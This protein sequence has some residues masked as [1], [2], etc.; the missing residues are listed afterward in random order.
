V[1][2]SGTASNVLRRIIWICLVFP[3]GVLLVALAV[4]NRHTVRLI[5]DPFAPDNPVLAVEAPLFL[6]LLGAVI[7]GLVLGGTVTWFGQG[8][9]RRTARRRSAE[10][11]SLRR[12][13][14]R[15]NAQLKVATQ[16]RLPQGASAD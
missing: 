2:P 12:E 1:T 15:L 14:E 8:R 13:T 7:A 11:A 5:L 16:Q 6:F 3:A 10:A 4:A 9:W